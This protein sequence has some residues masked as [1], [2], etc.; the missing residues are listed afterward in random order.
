MTAATATDDAA[1]AEALVGAWRLV[2]WTIEYPGTARVTEPFGVDPEG[3]LLYA[4]EGQMSAVLQRR[5]RP[6]LSSADVGAVG[7]AEKA[8]AFSGYLHYA[9]RWHVAG[10]CVVHEVDCALNP[11]LV[12]TRQVRRVTLR[13]HA[14]E[15]VAEECLEGTARSRRHALLWRRAAGS[16][17]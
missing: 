5:A 9:G 16:A 15:L 4:R 13:G 2:R 7:D 3:Q 10:G 12:G 17:L 14:L 6:R 8:R 11:N 1:L